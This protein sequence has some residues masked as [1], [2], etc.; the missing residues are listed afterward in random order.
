[1]LARLEAAQQ[2]YNACLGE[3]LK[4]VGLMQQSK[5]W[6]KAWKTG[7]KELTRA[8]IWEACLKY[9]FTDAALQ[10]Y[11]VKMRRSCWIGEHLDVHV[12]QKL[13]TRAF[14][15][16]QR[17]LFGQ[18]RKVRFKGKNQMDTVE[19]K[20]NRA[21]IRWRNGCVVWRGLTLPAIIDPEDPVIR[22]ALSCR[23]KYVRLVRRKISGRNRFYAQLICE[24]TPYRKPKNALGEGIVGIDAGPSI[25]ARVN[26]KEAV[27]SPLLQGACREG[28][29]DA[30][31][32][33]QAGPLP[34]SQQP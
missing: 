15:A 23:V 14:C 27:L 28:S 9:G 34:Q 30:Q 25:I 10:H 21:S 32:P 31:A 4:R 33:A 6:Q 17:V 5:L 18:T 16:A 1:L 29:G 13:G 8:L 26:S 22:H 19:G 7:D 20:S 24:G 2:L 12:V 11:A 3:A